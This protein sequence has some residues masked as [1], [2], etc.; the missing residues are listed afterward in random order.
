MSAGAHERRCAE[1]RRDDHGILGARVRPGHEVAVVDVSAAGI[2][3]ET[4]RRLLPGASVEMQ[5][6][7]PAR[8]VTIRGRV[9]RCAVARLRPAL[10]CYRGAIAF[11][12]CLPWFIADRSGYHV[13]SAELTADLLGGVAP[14][15]NRR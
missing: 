14:T 11:E 2:L 5:L 9:V 1:R 12:R 13:P 7:T 4:D 6:E 10:V 3:I 15:L 8:T